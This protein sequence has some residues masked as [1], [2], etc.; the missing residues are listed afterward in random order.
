VTADAHEWAVVDRPQFS[1]GDE[2]RAA[3]DQ[4]RLADGLHALRALRFPFLPDPPTPAHAEEWIRRDRAT[5]APAE[6]AGPAEPAEGGVHTWS[7][8]QLLAAY[9]RGE[10]SPVEVLEVALDRIARHDGALGSVHLLCADEARAAAEASARRWR[11]GEARPLDGVPFGVKDIVATAGIPTTGGSLRYADLVPARTATAVQRLV[12]AGAVLVA[13][14]STPEFAFGDARPGHEVANPWSADH[15]CGGSSSG[16]AVALASR[17]LPLA[18][19]TDTGGSI[20]V[21]SSYCGVTGLKPTQGRVPRD[22]VMAVSWTLDHTGPMARTAEDVARMLAVMA[23]A[24]PHDPASVDRPV[25]DPA[26]LGPDVRGLRI[27][28]PRQW[29]LE[30]CDDAVLE[31]HRDALRVLE[32]AGARV[33]DVDVPHAHLAGTIAWVITVSEFAALHDVEPGELEEFTPAAANRLV[34]GSLLRAGDYL[35]AL[36]ARSLVQHDF[37]LLWDRVDAIAT[38][39]T[40][41]PPPRLRPELDPMFRHG[42]EAWLVA[43]ARNFLVHD[44]T[45]MPALVMPS[46]WRDGLPLGIQIAAPPFAEATCL[47]IALAHQAAT[48]HHLRVPASVV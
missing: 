27:G 31:A 14:L 38:P 48:D 30:G 45:G 34:A 6:S 22:G 16:P 35:H 21:P 4:A 17:L 23:G 43:I 24:D 41:T 2:A 28:V 7:A 44:V 13:K 42:D 25:P 19:G 11:A 12:D 33:V 15:W 32:R 5:E 18:V 39:A 47:R 1:A 26:G 8:S 40:P 9:R 36:R 46:G 37:E 20:R 29:F 3:G 10:R